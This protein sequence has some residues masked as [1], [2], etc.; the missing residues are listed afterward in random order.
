MKGQPLTPEQ[1]ERMAEGRR[2]A[3]Q[4]KREQK[5]KLEQKD[6]AEQPTVSLTDHTREGATPSGVATFEAR[7]AR[8]AKWLVGIPADVAALITDDEIDRMEAEE[9]AKAEEERKKKALEQVRL[10]M[11]HHARVENDLM[12]A[13][14]LRTKEQ[15]EWLA[16]KGKITI[17]L[18]LNGSGD[19]AR[20][21]NCF[22]VNG[23]V[24]SNGHEYEVTRAEY[25]SLAYNHYGQWLHEL[26][27]SMLSQSD[28]ESA[29][30]VLARQ[31]PAFDFAPVR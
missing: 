2:L 31:I 18:P 15:R 4:K 8:R 25:Q 22:R 14:T 6:P 28:G 23:R 17:N 21:P 26:R 29:K 12:D 3:A 7:E 27:F 30:A 24:F 16:E 19:P 1:K 10:S 13:S 5:E 20:G 11:R 9:N